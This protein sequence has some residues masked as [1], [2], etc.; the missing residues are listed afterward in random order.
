VSR[1]LRVHGTAVALDGG[2]VLL[3]GPSGSGKSDLALRLIDGGGKLVADDQTLLRRERDLVLADAPA[4][5]AG[6]LEVRGVGLFRVETA[7]AVPLVVV[8][9]LILSSDLERLPEQRFEDV[10][11]LLVPVVDLAPFEASAPA[12]LRLLRR[13]LAA[14]PLPAIIG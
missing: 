9:D 5:I 1:S 3:R 6:L 4:P 12:K 14:T 8:A 11:G 13:A 10:L 7:A 2:A